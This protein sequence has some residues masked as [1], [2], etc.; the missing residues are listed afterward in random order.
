MSLYFEVT[1]GS[2]SG[3][4]SVGQVVTIIAYAPLSGYIFDS[5]K[6]A[7]GCTIANS[8]SSTT[9]ATMGNVSNAGVTATYKVNTLYFSVYSGGGDGTKTYGSTVSIYAD[10]P[11]AGKIFDSWSSI[12]NCS[13]ANAYASSTT[14]TMGTSGSLASV[15]ATYKDIPTLYLTVNEGTGDGTKSYGEVVNIVADS[16]AFGWV[17]YRWTTINNCS[18]ANQYAS[19]TTATMGSSGDFAS[20]TSSY[21][22][23]LYT[24]TFNAGSGGSISGDSSQQIYYNYDGTEVTAIPN[25]GYVFTGW[26]DSYPNASRTPTNVSASET[27]TAYFE[28]DVTSH[29]VT[30]SSDGRGYL[31]GQASQTIE[32]NGDGTEVIAVP[33][34][35]YSFVNWSD[36]DTNP[37]K[38]P[39]G[40]T[41]DVNYIAHFSPHNRLNMKWYA[42]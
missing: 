40:V 5:W 18:I 16:P 36:D 1:N 26:S 15:T 12:T 38:T 29:T 8:S 21:A 3:T 39:T 37:S 35:G 32:Y 28:L 7:Y 31:T 9:T 24:V 23:I 22:R 10:S 34:I 11:P 25:A 27:F 33:Y 42:H 2:G 30:F 19:S 14:A 17:F 4:K 13:V 20:V 41:V 6:Y